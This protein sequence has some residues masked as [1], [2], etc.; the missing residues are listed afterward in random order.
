MIRWTHNSADSA[1]VA[2]LRHLAGRLQGAAERARAGLDLIE[3]GTR[4]DTGDPARPAPDWSMFTAAATLHGL[5]APK[6]VTLDVSTGDGPYAELEL[7][8]TADVDLWAAVVGA[9]LQGWQ[10]YTTPGT[11]RWYA[12]ETE[13]AW[14]G[15]RVHVWCEE[16]PADWAMRAAAGWPN[17]APE[18]TDEPATGGETP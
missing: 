8:N 2:G 9:E 17:P 3:R 10:N 5:P 16:R 7:T 11:G 4:T 1:T 18:A 12:A 6:V 14:R 13:W 15:W